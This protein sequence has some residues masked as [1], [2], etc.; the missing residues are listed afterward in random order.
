MP[1]FGA[2]IGSRL[3]LAQRCPAAA[4]LGFRVVE[5][6]LPY[7]LPAHEM[8]RLLQESKL[9]MALINAPFSNDE[10]APDFRG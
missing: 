5:M 1:Q 2:H 10:A 7:A 6:Q 3:P 4:R 8:Q 9:E